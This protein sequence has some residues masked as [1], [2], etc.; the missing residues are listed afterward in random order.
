MAEG[1]RI[2]RTRGPHLWLASLGL[3]LVAGVTLAPL[4]PATWLAAAPARGAVPFIGLGLCVPFALLLLSMAVM[5]FIH[6][7]FWH[8]HFPDISFG[9]AGLVA[10]YYLWAF[11]L[12]HFGQHAM[13]HAAMEYYEFIALVGGLYVASGGVV[14]RVRARGGPFANTALLAAGA[15]LANIVGTT[16]ASVLLIRPFLRMNAGR[17]RPMHV[18]MFIF[19]VS[20]CGGCLTPIGDPPLYLGYIKGVP[21]FWT[22][23]AL[24]PQWLLCVGTLLV[25]FFVLD[26]RLLARQ[27]SRPSGASLEVVSAIE[28]DE[29]KHGSAAAISLRGAVG[30]TALA[31]IIAAVFLDPFLRSRG[32]HTPVPVGPAAQILIAAAAFFMTRPA[33][34]RENQ[35]TFFPILE[36]GLLFFGIFVTMTPA[37]AYLAANGDALG[38]TTPGTYYFATGALSGVLDNAPTYVNMLQVAVRPDAITPDRIEALLATDAGV[39]TLAAIS[40]GAVFF[41]AMTYIGNGPNFIVRAIADSSGVRMPSFFGYTLRA[42]LV[43]LPVLV[44]VYLV[45]FATGGTP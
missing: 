44:L 16:G 35:F 34:R 32:I 2:T 23:E 43:L 6:E 36:V 30:L 24:W 7:R 12:G 20:N 10:G 9:L 42:V 17:I 37:L 5:P 14:I 22:L 21:F 27:L 8:H 39:R 11:D 31:L 13:Q 40:T 28:G 38:L 26:S 15:V 45:S 1:M 33:L 19:I 29:T 4:A 3:G 18:V 41:G 25:L